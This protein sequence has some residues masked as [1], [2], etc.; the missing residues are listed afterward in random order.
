M[1]CSHIAVRLRHPASTPVTARDNTVGRSRRTPRLSRGLVMLLRTWIK[2]WRDKAFVVEAGIS[3]AKGL[4]KHHSPHRPHGAHA[5]TPATHHPHQS[6]S[7]PLTYQHWP[8]CPGA[9]SL[10]RFWLRSRT[11]PGRRRPCPRGRGRR[12]R[13]GRAGRR[14]P[15]CHRALSRLRGRDRG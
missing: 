12:R 6:G 3:A 15:P 2:G 4:I 7:S 13:H 11:Q 1:E 8:P 14:R 10:M 9:A 5:P